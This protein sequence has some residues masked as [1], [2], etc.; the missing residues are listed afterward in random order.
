MGVATPPYLFKNMA[1]KKALIPESKGKA[2]LVTPGNAGG[3][4]W[5]PDDV[6]VPENFGQV[7]SGGFDGDALC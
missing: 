3:K 5:L 6:Q 7:N 4:G 1:N 2:N